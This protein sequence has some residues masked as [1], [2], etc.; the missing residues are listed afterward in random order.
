MARDMGLPLYHSDDLIRLGWS[1]ASEV[2][3]DCIAW[4]SR[5]IYEGVATI[6]ALRKLLAR[7]RVRPCTRYL[8]L[9]HA[10]ENLTR[11]QA[12]MN[13]GLQTMWLR[14]VRGPL[15]ARGVEVQIIPL[16]PG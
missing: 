16:T 14:D 3:A 11:G 1:E 6:R 8:H 10:R 2:F 7:S 15:I 9:V 4:T 12:L 13:Q 5:G